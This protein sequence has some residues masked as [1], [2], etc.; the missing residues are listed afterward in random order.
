MRFLRASSA[1]AAA[2]LT[3]AI[4]MGSLV[5]LAPGAEGPKVRFSVTYGAAAS[6]APLDGRLLLLI[7][8]EPAEE[9]RLQITD[10]ALRS[11]QIF[12]V[13]V[14]GWKAGAPA[15]FEGDVLGFPARRNVS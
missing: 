15:V 12:G 14:D 2:A 7:S 13:D 9:P 1:I 3:V 8:K 10:N 6:S 11:Q 4:A 5:A